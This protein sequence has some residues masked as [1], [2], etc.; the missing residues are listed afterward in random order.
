MGKQKNMKIGYQPDHLIVHNNSVFVRCCLDSYALHKASHEWHNRTKKKKQEL[1][2]IMNEKKEAKMC[3]VK[4]DGM[5]DE[6]H[7]EKRRFQKE[8]ETKDINKET[9]KKPDKSNHNL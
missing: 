3:D 9:D 5:I 2:L 1:C 7:Q 6:R 4:C 8:R